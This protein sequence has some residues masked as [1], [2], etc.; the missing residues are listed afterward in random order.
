MPVSVGIIKPIY[1]S[2][3]DEDW[4]MYVHCVCVCDVCIIIRGFIILLLL[5]C[6]QGSYC[7]L[8]CMVIYVH[9]ATIM[10]L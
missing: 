8:F 2:V 1:I 10:L 5:A 6:G 7:I 4:Y 9:V 3:L